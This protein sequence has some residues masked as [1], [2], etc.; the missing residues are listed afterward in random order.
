MSST[1]KKNRNLVFCIFILSLLFK[2]LWLFNNQNL[3]IPGDDMSYWLHS[4]TIA[5]DYDLDYKNDYE[6]DSNIFNSET[7]VPSHP[8][9]AGY[10]ASPFVFLFSQLEKLYS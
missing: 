1:L 10:L 4:A 8:P 2:P 5:F 6:F 7:N 3:G 9:G